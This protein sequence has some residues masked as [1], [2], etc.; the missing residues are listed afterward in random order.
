[1]SSFISTELYGGAITV[2]LPATFADVSTIRQVPDNQEVYLE[3]DGFT[4]VIFDIMERVE[5]SQ[6]ANDEEALKFHYSDMVG[7]SNDATH[8]WHSNTA[9]LS[10]LPNIPAYT[11]VATQHPTPDASSRKPQPDFTAIVLILVRLAQQKT[12]IVITV[13][14]PHVPG[15]YPKEEVDFSKAKQGPLMDAAAAIKQLILQTFDIK[16]WNLFV[17]EE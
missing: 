13:N 5:Q 12:D 16:D 14:V 11:F 4:S 17:N 2:D 10:R 9:S 3:K 6:A 1:M 7:D 8:F 15:E